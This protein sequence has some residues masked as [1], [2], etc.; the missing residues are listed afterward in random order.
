M[1]RNVQLQKRVHAGGSYKYGNVEGERS[2]VVGARSNATRSKENLLTRITTYGC[3]SKLRLV[4]DNVFAFKAF[5]KGSGSLSAHLNVRA[6]AA[7]RG[8]LDHKVRD[9]QLP[10]CVANPWFAL[11]GQTLE[12][13]VLRDLAYDFIVALY[14]FEMGVGA[15]L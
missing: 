5:G 12:P 9:E 8:R 4:V 1:E 11:G 13:C 3:L 7:I 14:S 6:G 15:T 10:V 2:W